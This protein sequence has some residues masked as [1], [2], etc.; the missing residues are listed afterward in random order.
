LG[1]PREQRTAALIVFTTLCLCAFFTAQG[2]T[3]LLAAR[4]L[5]LREGPVVASRVG[6]SARPARRTPTS[7]EQILRRN[8]FDPVTGDVYELPRPEVEEGT[9]EVAAPVIPPWQPGD[10]TDPCEGSLRL[11]GAVV[12]PG[13]PEW[14]F[15]AM[16]DGS[17]KAMLYRPGMS[18]GSSEL[19]EVQRDRVVVRSGSARACHVA[20]FG[21]LERPARPTARAAAPAAEEESSEGESEAPTSTELTEGITRV[22]DTEYQVDRSLVTSLMSNQAELMRMARVIPHEENGQV[23]GVK[24][25]GIRRSS[26]LGRLGIRNGDM[27][28]SINGYDMTSPDTALQ[29]YAQL[30]STNEVTVNLQRRGQDMSIKFNLQD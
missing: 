10:P 1:N 13:T 28:R 5:P 6:G 25:Y 3:G 12:S 4:L 19:L 22:S 23:V 29:A 17:E 18:I 7:D 14:S 16:A 21:E 26:L 24:L 11:V 9:E 15:A 27:L 8:I 30:P 2:T 20:M